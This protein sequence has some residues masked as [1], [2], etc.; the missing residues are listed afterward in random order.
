MKNLL[1]P[2]MELLEV[3]G[4]KDVWATSLGRYYWESNLLKYVMIN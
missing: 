3:A 2:L 1:I 4:E